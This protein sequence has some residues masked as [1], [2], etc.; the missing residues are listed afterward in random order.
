[1][2]N[3][4]S[5]TLATRIGRVQSKVRNVSKN[6]EGYGYKY[7]DINAIV[8]ALDKPLTEEGLSIIHTVVGDKVFKTDERGEPFLIGKLYDVVTK[9][10]DG[11]EFIE[12]SCPVD[13]W[14][15]SLQGKNNPM[16]TMGAAITYA[17]RYNLINLFNLG[18]ADDDANSVTA[19]RPKNI[20]P[21]T[22]DVS[23]KVEAKKS[24][25]SF[26]K[27]T[28]KTVNKATNNSSAI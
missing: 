10:S 24:G 19:E 14:K 7:T 15:D 1:M 6:A 13:G 16:Q 9:I 2:A 18:T 3:A 11:C 23:P 4:K 27:N 20:V 25:T 17:R 12:I 26:R 21:T 8:K 22:K 5:E 28:T